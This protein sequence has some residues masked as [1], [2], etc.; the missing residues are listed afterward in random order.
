[1]SAPPSFPSAAARVVDAFT[2]TH[3]LSLSFG[4]SAA[5][6]EGSEQTPTQCAPPPTVTLTLADGSPAPGLFTL[7]LSD[8]DA[9]SVADPKFGEWQHWVHVNAPVYMLLTG[10]SVTA[11]FGPAPGKD[12]G[13]HRYCLVVYEQ[14]EPLVVEEPRISATSGFPPR[15]SFNSRA[16]AAKYG[17]T[18][19]GVLTFNAEWDESVPASAAKLQGLPPPAAA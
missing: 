6:A 12:T 11:Y 13:K 10:E 18:P 4:A 8:P 9:P 3:V 2:P 7:I 14:R 1:M 16:F 15:R 5:V 17:L 19:K